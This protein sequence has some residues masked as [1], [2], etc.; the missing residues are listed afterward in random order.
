[1]RAEGPEFELT[2]IDIESD[3]ELFKSMLERIPVIEI[4]GREVCELGLDAGAVS[5]VL[6][7]VS[8]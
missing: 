8:A 7:T 4:E 5:A 1:M 3:D 6:A 2:E